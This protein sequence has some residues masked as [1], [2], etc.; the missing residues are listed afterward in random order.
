MFIHHGMWQAGLSSTTSYHIRYTSVILR[1]Q[2]DA[3]STGNLGNTMQATNSTVLV[4]DETQRYRH[5]HHLGAT[6]N[7]DTCLRSR[8]VHADGATEQA[9]TGGPGNWRLTPHILVIIPFFTLLPSL[10]VPAR[11][12]STLSVG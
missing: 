9:T 12:L 11:L 7:E 10:L 5:R 2:L 4:L 6:R 8:P 1:R 3:N